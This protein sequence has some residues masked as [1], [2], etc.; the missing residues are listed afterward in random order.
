MA[1]NHTTGSNLTS[2]HGTER[3]YSSCASLQLCSVALIT[4][5]RPE[6]VSHQCWAAFT[7]WANRTDDLSGCC[8]SFVRK[9]QPLRPLVGP[10]SPR[11]GVRLPQSPSS[12]RQR[13]CSRRG[14]CAR[15][16]ERAPPRVCALS[17]WT[18]LATPV[19][20]ISLCWF[21]RLRQSCRTATSDFATVGSFVRVV[22]PEGV[23][24]SARCRCGRLPYGCWPRK[25]MSIRRGSQR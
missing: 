18:N 17:G 25:R 4:A 1:A 12:S 24:R 19:T 14:C 11:S 16:C 20:P 7:S 9:R 8:P 22:R 13:T 23:D 5:G 15:D 2:R 10:G 3:R 21:S 6:W